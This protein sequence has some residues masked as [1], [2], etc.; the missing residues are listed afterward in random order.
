MS[1]DKGLLKREQIPFFQSFLDSRGI[2]WTE[3]KGAFQLLQV[4]LGGKWEVVHVNSRDV[5][6]TPEAIRG[7]IHTFKNPSASPMDTERLDF[8]IDNCA[9]VAE[10]TAS[11]V[12]FFYLQF[13]NDDCAQQ[14]GF[15]TPREAIDAAIAA[16]KEQA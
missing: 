7:V 9:V 5:V 2:G 6:A 12:P 15:P 1:Y 3:G 4:F 16:A 14:D 10:Y 8:L 11:D 13:I